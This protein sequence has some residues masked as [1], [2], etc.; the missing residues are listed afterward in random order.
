LSASLSALV[1]GEDSFLSAC[2]IFS[3]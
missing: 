3:A 2:N 1:K